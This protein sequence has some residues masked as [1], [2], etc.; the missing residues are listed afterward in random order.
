MGLLFPAHLLQFLQEH[1][2]DPGGPLE[3][4]DHFLLPLGQAVAGSD[5]V[6]E[7]FQGEACGTRGAAR[8]CPARWGTGGPTPG[9]SQGPRV[10]SSEETLEQPVGGR[11][12]GRGRRGL[13]PGWY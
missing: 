7:A 12:P 11:G 2:S 5:G 1:L 6:G 13:K 4:G 3:T 10:G 8:T 9:P